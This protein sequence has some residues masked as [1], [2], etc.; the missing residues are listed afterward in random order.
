LDPDCSAGTSNLKLMDPQTLRVA[1]ARER[2]GLSVDLFNL[3]K[4]FGVVTLPHRGRWYV[5][6]ASFERVRFLLDSQSRLDARDSYDRLAFRLLL[7]G[8]MEVP[9]DRVMEYAG[10]VANRFWSSLRRLQRQHN[11][12]PVLG[13]RQCKL[14]SASITRWLGVTLELR[15]AARTAI[16]FMEDLANWRFR[17]TPKECRETL[18]DAGLPQPW[19]DAHRSVVAEASEQVYEALRC[20]DNSDRSFR[21]PQWSLGEAYKDCKP[22]VKEAKVIVQRAAAARPAIDRILFWMQPVFSLMKKPRESEV[23]VRELLFAG[24]IVFLT[25]FAQDPRMRSTIDDL[26]GKDASELT[27]GVDSLANTIA[28]LG[29]TLEQSQ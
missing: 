18:H 11:G 19:I 15:R 26:D 9:A 3:F 27:K 2:L 24:Q 28:C 22:P 29:C 12:S 13:P 1:E 20:S 17:P 6:P 4:K 16:A 5:P 14:M 8:D 25:V 21:S 10:T 7:E 23:Y